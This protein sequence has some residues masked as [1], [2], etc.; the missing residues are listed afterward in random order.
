MF[1]IFKSKVFIGLLMICSILAILITAG[2]TYFVVSG[3]PPVYEL[4]DYTPSISTK[5]YDK[6]NKCF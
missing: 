4:E 3:I 2:I 5:V 6:N 1:K